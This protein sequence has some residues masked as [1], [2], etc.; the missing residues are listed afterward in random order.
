M[1]SEVSTS[2]PGTP[3]VSLFRVLT[4]IAGLIALIVGVLILV[5]PGR[6]AQVGTGIVAVYAIVAGIVYFATGLFASEVGIWSR[7]GRIILGILFVAAG[8]I[9]FLNLATAAVWLLTFIGIVVGILWIID[10]VVSLSSLSS[11]SNKAIVVIFAIISI[12]AGLFLVF[13]P[14]WG[15]AVL[16]IVLGI[17]LIVLG[18][19]RIVAGFTVKGLDANAA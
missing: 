11:A 6:T 16:W 7:I 4:G 8:L 10:G 13:T 17:S 14:V 19:V 12:L 9:I 18:I 3:V 5:W 15:G 1:A 2:Q